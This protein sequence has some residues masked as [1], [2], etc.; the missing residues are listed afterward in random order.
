MA[1]KTT[2]FKI[3]VEAEYKS[4]LGLT[5]ELNKVKSNS[6]ALGL[7]TKESETLEHMLL[8]AEQLRAIID[9]KSDG[10]FGLDEAAFQAMSKNFSQLTTKAQNF[11]KALIKVLK[12]DVQEEITKI[13]EK[14]AELQA[15]NKD[16]GRAKG[17]ATAKVNREKNTAAIQAVQKFGA[18]D[19][20]GNAFKTYE[21][22]SQAAS[23]LEK[24]ER[25]L[26]DREKAIAQAWQEAQQTILP[27]VQQYEQAWGEA[28]AAIEANRKS[29]AALQQEKNR[30]LEGG[31]IAPELSPESKQA[32]QDYSKVLNSMNNSLEDSHNQL[33]QYKKEQSDATNKQKKH[34]KTVSD[35]NKTIKEVDKSTKNYNTTLGKAVYNVVSYG[36]ALT[37][38]RTISNKF[39][40]TITEMDKALTDMTVVTE[41]TREQA[42]HLTGQLQELANQTGMTTTE[43]AQ[44]TT[45]Y[46][47]QG[48]TLSNALTLTETAAKAA[49]IA[50]ISGSESINLLTN[51]MNGFQMS[52]SQATE[53]SD[54]FAALA[55]EAATDYEELAT[56]L[57]KVA[58]QANLAGMSMDFTLGLLTKGI[59]VTRE[60]P[61]TIGTAL[62]TVIS[63]MRELTDYG[64]TLE[65][66]V[67]V[68]RVDTALKNIGVSLLDTNREF[69]DLEDVLTEVGQKW[70][71]L[72]KNQQANVA[73]ALAGT[74][75][76]SRLI[77]MMQDFDR[78]QELVNISMNS[79]GTTAAQHR[80]YMQGLEAA[81]T[82]L[83]TSYQKLIT[84]FMNSD[85]AIGSIN[86]LSSAIGFLGDNISLV[87]G[88]LGALGAIYAPIIA[89]KIADTT[90]TV[91]AT[92]VQTLY[93]KQ[94]EKGK[95][96]ESDLNDIQLEGVT[97]KQIGIALD[98]AAVKLLKDKNEEETKAIIVEKLMADGLDEA[99]ASQLANNAITKISEK[100]TRENTGSLMKRIFAL[101]FDTTVKDM[102]TQATLQGVA[103]QRAY[104]KA[105]L[106]FGGLVI[107]AAIGALV[108]AWVTLNKETD[109]AAFL[110]ESI[111]NLIASVGSALQST[112][113]SIVNI[114]T[115]LTPVINI[116][117]YAIGGIVTGVSWMIDAFAEMPWLL[118]ILIAALIVFNATLSGTFASINKVT[119]ATIKNTIVTKAHTVALIAKAAAQ[120]A[121]NALSGNWVGIIAGGIALLAIAAAAA[122]K[123]FSKTTETAEEKSKRL[124]EEI[125]KNQ[126]KIYD[127]QKKS[128]SLSPLI[129]EYEKLQDK[130]V[131]TSE[132][133]ERM[134][135]I[136]SEIGD[137]DESYL[138]ANGTVNWELV[139]QTK[140]EADEEAAKLLQ[141]D[142][143]KSLEAFSTGII[144]QKH[145]EG[146]TD[147]YRNQAAA[148]EDINTTTAA[149]IASNYEQIVNNIQKE[150][151]ATMTKEDFDALYDSV[152]AVQT[153]IEDIGEDNGLIKQFEVYESKI[154][155]LP[156]TAKEAF[157]AM[158]S[159][160]A[161]Y[162]NMISDLQLQ[163]Q[164]KTDFLAKIANL[165]INE[166]EYQDLMEEYMET[167]GKSSEDFQDW[168]SLSVNESTGTKSDILRKM[169]GNIIGRDLT[170]G[171]SSL[172]EEERIQYQ[173]LL[174]A[175]SSAT[176]TSNQDALEDYTKQISSADNLTELSQKAKAGTM[177]LDDWRKLQSEN[178]DIF[179]DEEKYEQF[180]N[181]QYTA[182]DM[183]T[184]AAKKLREEL[185]AQL[186]FAK[187]EGGD[188][189]QIKLL[190]KQIDDLKY[191][192]LYSSEI[193]KN[194]ANQ[195]KEQQKQI[196][197][198]QTLKNLTEEL[199]DLNENDI[200]YAQKKLDILRK[201]EAVYKEQLAD[202]KTLLE[203]RRYLE[204]KSQNYFSIVNGEVIFDAEK[205]KQYF[206]D[207]RDF[208]WLNQNIEALKEAY[209]LQEE[210][211]NNTKALLD[212]YRSIAETQYEKEKEMLEERKT[213]YEDYFDSLDA[214]EEEQERQKSRDDVVRQLAALSGGIGGNTKT[215]QKE[216]MQELEE[217]NKEEEEARKQ[218]ARDALLDDMDSHIEHID[219]QITNLK[220][221]TADELSNLLNSMGFDVKGYDVTN[222]LDE[223]GGFSV[224][225]KYKEG[226]YVDFT[227]PAWV[228]GTK[229]EPESFLDATDTALLRSILD[230]ILNNFEMPKYETSDD[231]DEEWI[232]S[233]VIENIDIHTDKLNTNQ[234]FASAGNTLAK[235]LAKIIRERGLNV[236]AKK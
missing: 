144:E 170:L 154:A 110:M 134:K 166:Q 117:A 185:Q 228:D 29:I 7:T 27:F 128:A 221:L 76:Q 231:E 157:N 94:I 65:D 206:Q 215:L 104:N 28:D 181:G 11:S 109:A 135:E 2:T 106:A 55:A 142:L 196:R 116:L 123:A 138:N 8:A 30:I 139:K 61:E 52:A 230:S 40:Q 50:G 205:A 209:K 47:Q 140:Q 92:V 58:A 219:E 102:N 235:E 179:T 153:Q 59:E 35:G 201:Q 51:A 107:V 19:Q 91:A 46:L 100:Y 53:V 114:L 195:T 199:N 200:D 124:A 193:W 159:S 21:D 113:Q 149:N 210:A 22:L 38:V 98:T 224:V 24:L 208:E 48:E 4:L 213:S 232:Q 90:A 89:S 78:T 220:S 120:A 93:N 25:P 112:G 62:K 119:L 79:A 45:M 184:E 88:A 177:T 234:D 97:P 233:I 152:V 226:G 167:T 86:A 132:D 71:T 85:I 26:S 173:S 172:T 82:A 175:I 49:R 155:S 87:Y 198:N 182:L 42:W 151:L 191:V 15:A 229:A 127:A 23:K 95:K 105:V 81:T 214:L 148:I 189:S 222:N 111:N 225:P 143:D 44:M 118:G 156:D 64:E 126:E 158:Y 43:V 197:L 204:A 121:L 83:T 122:I 41:L 66:G 162:A 125:E 223:N 186:D 39:I 187:M 150:N 75:Q 212:E 103:A 147:Y 190:E 133:L 31:D 183:R 74:R 145:I 203:D 129:D 174:N 32:V 217:L 163:G 146:I 54:K 73:V 56:A 160:Y 165:G 211:N 168:F 67:D 63:R 202:A 137:L 136:E 169:I 13:D 69:R 115:A 57:S 192:S 36:S 72:N 218:A 80:K 70:D 34:N 101:K 171:D 180:I 14:I 96:Y 68:N 141:E 16:S 164:A 194:Y 20:E 37:L 18:V 207:D 77:A 33:A 131:K 3:N 227:G 236:N 161:S 10:N 84:N 188:Q 99:T 1:N 5:A 176:L 60:A 130:V 108:A 6:A 9:K 178:P 17:R 12:P 216:L